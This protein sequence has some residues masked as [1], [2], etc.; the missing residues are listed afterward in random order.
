MSSITPVTGSDISSYGG[1]TTISG[2]ASSATGTVVYVSIQDVSG[3]GVIKSTDGGSTWT[4]VNTELSVSSI[5]CSSDGSIVHA[6]VLGSGLY[7]SANSGATWNKVI[8][9][10]NNVLPGG[11][12]NPESPFGGQ[13]PGC[14]LNNICQIACDS[15]GS[16][17]LMTTNAAASLYR[18]TNRG[19]TWSFLYAPPGY[20]VNN[21][22]TIVASSA[23]GQVLYAALN[24]N[25]NKTIIVS[26]NAGATW[27]S[28]PM[29]GQS[30]PFTALS[31]NSYGDFVFG[32][33]SN[34]D[35]R[36][37]YPTHDDYASLVPNSGT[38]VRRI[39]SYNSGNNIAI[40]QTA[41]S[42]FT[43]G[44]VVTYFI[45]NNYAP[46]EGTHCFKEDS[47][48]L[49]LKDGEEV[50]IK[51]QDIRKGDLVK[52]VKNG[53]VPVDTTTSSSLYNSGNAV[54]GTD[55]L[56]VCSPSRYPGLT[57]D[58]VIT[59]Y[60][61]ILVDALSQTQRI[62]TIDALGRIMITNNKYRLMAFLDERAVP[63]NKEGNFPIWHITLEHSDY[64]MNYGI[65]AN[66]L[67]VEAC[68][69]RYC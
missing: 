40:A 6:V 55:R 60:Q 8:Y 17:L 45:M 14:T 7:T 42:T 24:T 35:I 62:G 44:V 4:T 32:V 12:D 49:C 64:Y 19:V 5:A 68:G 10:P 9:S 22:S 1:A 23:N 26:R 16:T 52:T 33:N 3:A 56:Y 51:V 11:A 36:I 2:I 53:Y 47:T 67:L 57:E 61:S 38:T 39:A 50:Y 18:S 15:S 25:T 29:F 37:F 58:L 65:Y 30:G 28:I 46:N 13:F 54:R 48:I 27:A 20:G 59:G 43:N 21:D 63:F 69:K 31:T 34:S 41:Y 66:G